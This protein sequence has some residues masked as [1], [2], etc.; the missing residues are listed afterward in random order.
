M[1][2]RS[3]LR[4]GLPLALLVVALAAA[5]CLPGTPAPAPAT[6]IPLP[7]TPIPPAN[8]EDGIQVGVDADGNF[9]RGNPNAPVKLEE[10]SE[11]Q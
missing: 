4:A 10:F 5:A 9:Y 2:N 8:S 6:D 1:I 11:F 7:A 3:H